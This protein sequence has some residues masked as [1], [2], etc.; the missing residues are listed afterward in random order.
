MDSLFGSGC[1]SWGM[2]LSSTVY[3][4]GALFFIPVRSLWVGFFYPKTIG[5]N[6]TT[7]SWEVG[8]FSVQEFYNEA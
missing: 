4:A 3:A 6:Q 1:A 7:H 8:V 2:T 5:Q